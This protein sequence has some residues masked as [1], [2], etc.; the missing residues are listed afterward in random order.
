MSVNW[1]SIGSENGLWPIRRQAIIWANV[2]ILLIGPLEKKISEIYIKIQNF[3]FTNMY[4]K[5][6]SAKWRPFCLGVDEFNRFSIL[7]MFKKSPYSDIRYRKDFLTWLL[8]LSTG[9]RTWCLNGT[10]WVVFQIMIAVA[11]SSGVMA[12]F[13]QIRCQSHKRQ[14]THWVLIE[15]ATI[16]KTFSN[17]FYWM[18]YTCILI[19]IIV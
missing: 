15:M 13:C 12:S 7:W 1:V 5:I 9:Y 14:L 10:R 8:S 19:D 17:A 11:G 16:L 2:G 6:S 4:L 3:S 18:K